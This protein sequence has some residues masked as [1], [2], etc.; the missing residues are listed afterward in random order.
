MSR[1]PVGDPL[2][3]HPHLRRLAHRLLPRLALHLPA[4]LRRL[5]RPRQVLLRHPA[6][7]RPVAHDVRREHDRYE[8]TVRLSQL[9]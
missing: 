7:D 9:T 2:V 1:H 4:S 6:H 3:P 5:H 8:A